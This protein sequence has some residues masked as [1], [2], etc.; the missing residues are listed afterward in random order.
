MEA[1]H[2]SFVESSSALRPKSEILTSATEGERRGVGSGGARCT[3]TGL[4][5][6]GRRGCTLT[7][8]CVEKYVARLHVAVDLVA[9]PMQVVEAREHARRELAKDHLRERAAPGQLRR[10][11]HV[12]E[13]AAV[14]VPGR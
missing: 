12:G 14:H 10:M 3:L 9:L 4:R 1:A 8:A 7:S 13:R 6:S 5:P 11:Q 2:I